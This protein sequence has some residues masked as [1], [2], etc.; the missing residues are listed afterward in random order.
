[1]EFEDHYAMQN[2]IISDMAEGVM[3]IRSNGRVEMV[4]DA[5]LAILQIKREDLAGRPFASC[6]FGDERNDAFT[7][8][9]L[10]TVR[11]KVR[12]R[13]SYVPYY[14]GDIRKELRVVSSYLRE[15]E[16]VIGIILVLSDITELENLRDAV[17]AMEEIQALNKK[18]ELRNRLLKNTFGRYL[19]DDIVREILDTPDGMRLGGQKRVITVMMSDLRGFTMLCERMDPQ[20]V[21][22]MLNHYFSVMYE[23]ISRFKGTIIE[24]LGDG[25]FVI[26]GAPESSPSHAA[27][28]VACAVAMQMRMKEVNDWNQEHGF[29]DLYMGIALNTGGMILGNI[30]SEKRTKYGVMGAGVNLTGR[31]ESY[32]G[33]GHILVAPG[34]RE[35]VGPGLLQIAEVFPASPKGV[36]GEIEISRVTGIGG[37]YNLFLEALPEEMTGVSDPVLV[38]MRKLEGKHVVGDEIAGQV[39]AVSRTEAL[40]ETEAL[41]QLKRDVRIKIG[42][43]LYAKVVSEETGKVPGGDETVKT[44]EASGSEASRNTAEAA[45]SMEPKSTELPRYVWKV[46]FTAKPEGFDAWINRI[47]S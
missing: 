12:R 14:V 42:G 41:L 36:K 20:D 26:F 11:S 7:E 22:I 46:L 40:I 33:A 10:E 1:M 31:I 15:D 45:G 16:E 30:G 6:F 21:I 34:T 17:K 32:A 3:A 25:M 39:V 43:G 47:L 44:G 13:I 27:D 35:A 29:E 18:L 4:N 19:S 37:K 5:A 38:S 8:T 23:E 24:F 28:A 9:V 2:S